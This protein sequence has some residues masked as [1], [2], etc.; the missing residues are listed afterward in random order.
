VEVGEKIGEQLMGVERIRSVLIGD[1]TIDEPIVRSYS[2]T[3]GV[4]LAAGGASRFGDQKLL[5]TWEGKPL[6]Q[7]A[8]EAARAGGLDPIVVVVGAEGEAIRSVIEDPK[9]TVIENAQW[10][11]GQSSSMRLGLQAVESDVDAVVFLLGDMPLVDGP[12]I[13][14][15]LD[16]HRSTLAPIVAP[17]LGER[18]GNPVLFDRITFTALHNVHGDRGGRVIYDQFPVYP[19]E[20]GEAA[21][22]DIDTAEDLQSLKPSSG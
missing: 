6:V 2:R 19:I 8:V 14:A 10:E 3:A 17:Q 16:A 20:W 13:Q 22:V 1:L 4:I 9:I 5:Y 12:L 21:R 11:E 15:L 7:W 18:L